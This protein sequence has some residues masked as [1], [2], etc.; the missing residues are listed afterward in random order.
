MSVIRVCVEPFVLFSGGASLTYGIKHVKYYIYAM[1]IVILKTC[2]S[3]S[4]VITQTMVIFY[5]PNNHDIFLPGL[6]LGAL[7]ECHSKLPWS[8]SFSVG[9]SHYRHSVKTY[10]KIL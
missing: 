6:F 10:R 7:L 5:L 4:E 8:F 1:S 2:L 9:F 3:C